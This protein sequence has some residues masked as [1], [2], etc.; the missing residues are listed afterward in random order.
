MSFG[1]SV[2]DITALTGLAWKTVQKCRNAGSQHEEL[3]DQVTSVHLVLQ[4]FER[5]MLTP[6]S[7]MHGIDD[8]HREEIGKILKR[9]QKPLKL[10]DK[11]LGRYNGLRDGRKGIKDLY[12]RVRFSNGEVG[13]LQELRTTLTHQTNA[14]TLYLNIILVGASGRVERQLNESSK[15]LREMKAAVNGIAASL[16]M[17]AP[18]EGSVLTA[19]TQDDGEV[20]RQFRRELISKGFKSSFLQ[21]HEPLI[22]AYL[23]ELSNRGALDDP[24]L[25]TTAPQTTHLCNDDMEVT[26]ARPEPIVNRD[27]PQIGSAGSRKGHE[28]LDSRGKDARDVKERV[29]EMTLPDQEASVGSK[30]PIPNHAPETSSSRPEKASRLQVLN[31]KESSLSIWSIPN[32]KKETVPAWVTVELLSTLDGNGKRFLQLLHYRRTHAVSLSPFF[33]EPPYSFYLEIE[34]RESSDSG[35]SLSSAHIPLQLAMNASWAN[36]SFWL[37]SKGKALQNWHIWQQVQGPPV[38]RKYVETSQ[39]FEYFFSGVSLG[40]LPDTLWLQRFTSISGPGIRL[41]RRWPC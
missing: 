31:Q 17:Q 25:T 30:Q 23:E 6:N 41:T 13:D 27:N 32:S 11:L 19:Y 4:R 8:T 18:E 1:I 9:C 39:M 10:M 15:E 21:K 16:V 40:H 3:T 24:V 20:W 36:P 7:T 12:Q 34:S 14:L 29:P 28:N 37:H 35:K 26:D 5:E 38:E 33:T 2:S 22:H